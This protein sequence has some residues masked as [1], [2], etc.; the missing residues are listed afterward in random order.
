MPCVSKPI[1]H[2]TAALFA[3]AIV[4]PNVSGQVIVTSRATQIR[5]SG[6]VH[7]Q[8]NTTSTSGVISSEWVIR[9]ARLT[10]DVT[11]NDF[12]SGRVMPEFAEGGFELQD[13][14]V[15]LTFSPSFQV[16]FGQFKRPFDLFELT[17][18]TQILVIERTGS[19]RG[20]DSCAGASGVCTLSRL[21]EALEF[22]ARD[23]GAMVEFITDNATYQFSVTN[24][25]GANSPDENGTKSYT[26]RVSVSAS[27]DVTIS[28]NVALHDY[29]DTVNADDDFAL[30][31]GADVEY[32][33]FDS[34]LHIQAGVIGGQ[35]WG[36]LDLVGDP[37]RFLTAQGILS[38]KSPVTNHKF[39][40][41]IEPVGRLSF[42]DPDTDNGNDLGILITPGLA[43]HFV[44]RNKIAANI[45]VWMPDVGETEWS[46]KL[47]SYLH[48]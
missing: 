16:K 15:R 9:R 33:N 22:S 13:A 45:D 10:A 25:A 29:M 26:G 39:V 30:A 1:Y 43:V 40:S 14:Y 28:G 24:G 6:R 38:Y 36:T 18:S 48:F 5:L 44:G 20:V 35:N 42:A 32:G 19:I 4:A 31:Y 17:S 21:S 46:F 41:A 3:T 37:A 2:L 27:D 11:V 7:T 8:F 47:Q 23:I 34:G 12:V